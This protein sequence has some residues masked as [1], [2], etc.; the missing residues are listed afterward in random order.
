MSTVPPSDLPAD[1]IREEL[2]PHE[3]NELFEQ[4]RLLSDKRWRARIVLVLAPIVVA[5]IVLA[6]AM[7]VIGT[8][9]RVPDMFIFL[10]TYRY[11]IAIACVA[12]AALSSMA[13]Y[14]QTGFRRDTEFANAYRE[15]VAREIR[16][17][18]ARETT[19]RE[20]YTPSGAPPTILSGFTT[21]TT[22]PREVSGTS[23][24]DL[25][26]AFSSPSAERGIDSRLANIVARS[27]SLFQRLQS[28]TVRLG[29]RG[30]LN[31]LIGIAITAIG[32][33]ALIYYVNTQ[34]ELKRDDLPWGFL[35][36]FL[37]RISVVLLIEVFA[38]FF[39]QLYKESLGDIKY[40]QNE[41]TSIEARTLALIAAVELNDLQTA[42]SVMTRFSETERNII[43]KKDESTPD[44][45]RA[46]QE[47]ARTAEILKEI[48][49]IVRTGVGKA[50]DA[51]PK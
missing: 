27:A 18:A 23:K 21:E 20:E 28:E 39:L 51:K 32:V 33:T 35:G 43:L 45:K 14:L 30:N 41:M 16:K 8:N 49:S 12:G 36:H 9:A 10:I 42:A 17:S 29:W 6:F 46:E 11:A 34:P 15:V 19:A 22:L 3:F 44:L 26:N 13:M 38:Y 47:R 4:A 5:I 37:P 48:A 40:F 2:P 7:T 1:F 31:L 24:G 25:S 50:D